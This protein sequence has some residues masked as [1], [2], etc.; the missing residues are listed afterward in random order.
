M[1]LKSHIEDKEKN[2]RNKPMSD[3]LF[4]IILFN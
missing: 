3:I 1:L 2:E 4:F